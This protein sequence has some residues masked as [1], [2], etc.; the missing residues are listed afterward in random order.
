MESV[1]IIKDYVGGMNLYDVC[2]KYHI[3]K[4]K[5]KDILKSN[6]VELRKRGKQA[7]DK[8]GY[9]V[10]DFHI[11]KYKEEDGFY[12]VAIDK[13]N[14][15]SY[16]DYMNEAGLLTTHIKNTYN[17]EIP[18][19]YDRH[20]YYMKT[21]NY[22]WEQWFD[23]VKKKKEDTI[24]CPYC[25]WESVDI[26]NKS[27]A[28]T[29]H[30]LSHGISIEEH[31]NHHPKDKNIFKKQ[32]QII[33]KKHFLEDERNYVI[34]PICNQKMS[35]ITY[36]HLR[37][38][39][40]MC[41]KEFKKLYPSINLMSD[42]M[43]EQ[44]QEEQKKSNLVVSK[45]RFVSKYE[46]E[47]QDF[48][49]SHNINFMPNR[50]ILI[51]KEIDM[52]IED[53]RI[54]I[55]FDGLKWHTEWFGKKDRNYHCNKTNQCNEKGYGLI[56]IFE[57]E[58]VNKK[59]IVF[60]KLKHI[61]KLNYNLPKVCGRKISVKEIYKYDAQVFLEQYHIQGFSSS[62]VYLGGFY[63][64]ELVAVMTFKCGNIMNPNW[65]LTRFATKPTYYYQGVASKIFT[66]F[67]RNYNPKI[68]VSFADRR[69]TPWSNNNL[70]VKLG[71]KLESINKPDYKYYNASVERYKRFHKMSFNKQTLH[72]KYGFPLTMTE[73]E[74]AKE[75]GF[76]R[77]WDCGLFKFVWT[78]EDVKNISG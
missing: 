68:I 74:M 42:Y 78:S 34:C 28:Y 55:E 25:N 63:G 48:L 59:E 7:F 23:I 72:R 13:E 67:V 3:G 43:L 65:E 35:K 18:S 47:I 44:I 46:K 75:L 22:W 27:G 21:G 9:V 31:L 11:K 32:I 38:V 29:S 4:L 73:T 57:D 76:D 56:H 5:V 1:E 40:N 16:N 61:L 6:G 54:G 62:T 66:Y 36:S 30:I 37:N 41:V 71:F 14:G 70:Y 19:L 12:Y 49:S 64:D 10:S 17:V 39:H 69:W 8:S 20:I 51:G 60:N 53:K 2:A 45:D 26:N 50:Q 58:F 24:K 77:I 15:V 52:L 33:E